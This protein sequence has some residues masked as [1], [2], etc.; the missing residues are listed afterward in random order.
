MPEHTIAA[1]TA[2]VNSD[3]VIALILVL[4]FCLAGLLTLDDYGLTFD[5]TW[6]LFTADRY[7][8]FWMTFDRSLLDF[9]RP[10]PTDNQPDSHPLFERRN[11]E[12]RPA[13]ANT[14]YGLSCWLFSDKLQWL[15]P[16]DAYH[17]PVI[18]MAGGTLAVVY[19]MGREAIG[20]TAAF[21]ATLA[22]GLSPR[23][24]AHAHF[25]IK[26]TPKTFLFLADRLDFLESRCPSGLAMDA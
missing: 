5:E 12:P 4:A 11:N 14:L 23:F 26:D 16:V 25:N 2:R 17:L 21:F 7:F 3:R 8:R 13:V 20:Q 1:N 24:L 10:H 19:A 9:S 22:L 15:D 6:H 18:L